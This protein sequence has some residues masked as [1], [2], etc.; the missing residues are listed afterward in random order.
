VKRRGF[1][2]LS[3]A[4]ACGTVVGATAPADR[5]EVTGDG[6]RLNGEP[7]VIRSGEMHY[8]RVPRAYWRDRMRAMRAMGLNT[9]CT[10]VFWN[11]HEPRPGRFD[12][13]ANNDLAAYV[14]TAR[15]EGLHVI[16]RPGPYICT[17]WDFGGLPAWLLAP[18]A[19]TV[20][21]RDPRF[22]AAAGRYLERVGREVAAL[23]VT[24]GGPI[25]LCQVEN[26]Y[27]SFGSDHVYMAA[28]RDLI[29]NAGFDV[30]LYTSDG[31]SQRLLASGTL[32]GLTSVIN[33]GDDDAPA[34][35]FA[36]LSRFRPDG[37]RMCGEFWAGWFDHW[38]ET[39]H[40]TPPE[41]AVN[42]IGWMLAHNISFNIYMFHGGTSFGF[43]A[44]ANFSRV[45]QPDTTSYDY[46]APLDEAGRPTP[47]F[48]ALQKI[49]GA[50]GG[51][52]LP[53]PRTGI[54]I[55]RFEL[56]ESAP[57]SQLL[58]APHR[59]T[60]PLPMEA[61]GQSYG[62][63]W[64]RTRIAAGTG[65]L[66]LPPTRGYGRAFQNGREIDLAS[67]ALTLAA[68]ELDIVIENMGRINFGP[69]LQDNLQGL[70]GAV[71]FAGARL[72]PWDIYPLPLSGN[73]LS[74]IRF[75]PNPQPGPA[76]WRA[77]FQVEEA[78]DC[79]LDL[80]G[81]GKGLVWVNGHNLGRFWNRGPQFDLFLPGCWLKSGQ[82]EV[83]VLDWET[84]QNATLAASK[85][86]SWQPSLAS[87]SSPI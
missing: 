15:Q 40:T 66:E 28:V 80:R 35:G 20:R 84:H 17:E 86:R 1:L 50:A 65:A 14:R 23:Q 41:H 32:P 72:G 7:F 62:W 19:V 82:N 68:G 38:G 64:Y 55:P 5:F 12:F 45:Y 10:Y 76:F 85:D 63:I 26:E 42:G 48:R 30:P 43:M 34:D 46:D 4:A 49:L 74:A 47:K 27:G 36:A 29:R 87:N 71:R 75:L 61:L 51:P 22:L 39:H 37:P 31:P 24:R 25:L 54:D 33:F 58:R 9:L 11:L 2:A 52:S 59:S 77:H 44:G 3:A 70:S 69:K 16:L 21:S 67:R 83:I 18:T 6:F 57:V 73:D 56:R 78:G 8:P 79:F 60:D 53:Q 81:W 13:S